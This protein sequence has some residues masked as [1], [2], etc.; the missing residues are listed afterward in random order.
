VA[1][2]TDVF[3]RKTVGWR[4][5]SSLRRDLALDALEQVFHARPGISD[6]MHHSDR[7]VQSLSIRHSDR[8]AKAGVEAV[9][10]TVG[11]SYDNAV[12]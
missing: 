4:M 10:G 11:N 9:V 3:S 6:L 8:L 7:E 1:G 2:L 12:P 5:L